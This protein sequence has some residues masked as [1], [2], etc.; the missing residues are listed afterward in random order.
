MSI[1]PIQSLY[2]LKP[3]KTLQDVIRRFLWVLRRITRELMIGLFKTYR[4][5]DSPYFLSRRTLFS[6]VSIA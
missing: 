3:F 5:L 4:I 2:P 6:V 1:S